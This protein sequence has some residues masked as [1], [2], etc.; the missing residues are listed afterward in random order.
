MRCYVKVA[1]AGKPAPLI[2]A[3]PLP[4]CRQRGIIS[5]HHGRLLDHLARPVVRP[6]CGDAIGLRQARLQITDDRAEE[7]R[8]EESGPERASCVLA[9]G[10]QQPQSGSHRRG[11]VIKLP[12]DLFPYSICPVRRGET[13]GLRGIRGGTEGMGAHMRD[14]S[15]LSGRSSGRR[16]CGSLYLARWDATGEAAADSLCDVKLATCES[17][18]PGDQITRTAIAWSSRLEDLQ[19]VLCAVRRPRRDGPPVGFAQCLRGAHT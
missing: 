7:T 12:A 4:R 1:L 5:T 10:R 6:R 11:H 9:D 14:G 13:S 18:R 15:G 3:D 19:Y 16:R 8:R 17:P 2:N